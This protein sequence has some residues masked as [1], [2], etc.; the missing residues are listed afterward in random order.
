LVA[1]PSGRC[2]DPFDPIRDLELSLFPLHEKPTLTPMPRLSITTGTLLAASVLLSACLTLP[3]IA[4][5]LE[6]DS[7]AETALRAMS[8]RLASAKTLRFSAENTYDP[9]LADRL[10]VPPSA[11]VEVSVAR[12]DR[13]HARVAAPGSSREIYVDGETLTI[14]DLAENLYAVGPIGKP[15]IDKALDAV[16]KFYGFTPPLA[17][18]IVADPFSSMTR[19]SRT[20]RFVGKDTV[21]GVPCNHLAFTGDRLDWELWVGERDD[22]PL[23]Y[24]VTANRIEGKPRFTANFTSWNLGAAIPPTRFTFTPPSGAEEIPMLGAS[25]SPAPART[26]NR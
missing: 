10:G 24:V 19:N 7:A 16:S 17:D 23:R 2:S 26:R 8:D 25:G 1:S 3:R 15:D 9:S 5:P 14:H 20:G 11:A 12:P 4:A 6:M 18:F 21:R 22:L 13:I